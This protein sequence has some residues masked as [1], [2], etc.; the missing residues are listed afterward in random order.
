MSEIYPN[1]FEEQTQNDPPRAYAKK[2]CSKHRNDNRKFDFI[3]SIGNF[4]GY[5][6]VK[7]AFHNLYIQAYILQFFEFNFWTMGH[8]YCYIWSP[9]SSFSHFEELNDESFTKESWSEYSEDHELASKSG[10]V[11]PVTYVMSNDEGYINTL[12]LTRGSTA[13]AQNLADVASNNAMLVDDVF[14]CFSCVRFYL[15]VKGRRGKFIFPCYDHPRSSLGKN[16]L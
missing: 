2:H 6:L 10:E 16:G 12:F 5:I 15:Y 13:L 3:N 11:V 14:L 8:L 4:V 9:S 7:L 1:E